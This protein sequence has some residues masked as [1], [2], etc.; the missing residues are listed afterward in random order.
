[1][2]KTVKKPLK[3][4]QKKAAKAT[5]KK[6]LKKVT[7]A[8]KERT[9]RNAPAVEAIAKGESATP[10]ANATEFKLVDN[11]TPPPRPRFTTGVS[12]YPFESMAVGQSFLYLAEVID[13]SL[14]AGEREANKAQSEACAQVANRM[15]GATRR[16]SK[17]HPGYK[18]KITTVTN[19]KEHGF[20]HDIGIVVKR[21]A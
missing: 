9:Q 19:G 15:S 18:F 8:A 10:K 17:T 16:F 20:E 13:A 21:T 3:Q 14:Y 12:R 4:A 1:M 6:P 5:A 2:A 7:P 11:F